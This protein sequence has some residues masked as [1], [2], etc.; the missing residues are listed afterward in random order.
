MLTSITG[1]PLIPEA[2]TL[3]KRALFRGRQFHRAR[4][5][6]QHLN[7]KQLHQGVFSLHVLVGSFKRPPLRKSV[8]LAEIALLSLASAARAVNPKP[9]HCSLDR[10]RM[11]LS[12]PCDESVGQTGKIQQASSVEWLD[13]RLKRL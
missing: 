5:R 7:R 6:L 3:S 10:Q 13:G 1:E 9:L 8:A 2:S 4:R 12:Q 11:I